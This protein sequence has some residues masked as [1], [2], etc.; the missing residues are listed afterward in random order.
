MPLRP[1]NWLGMLLALSLL[2]ARVFP[3]VLTATLQPGAVDAWSRYTQEAERSLTRPRPLLDV[4]GERP[5]FRDLNPDGDNAGAEVPN[6]YIHHWIG[7]VRIPNT[8]VAAVR[9]VLEDYSHYLRTYAPD[10]KLAA[11]I[12]V[13]SADGPN[14]GR[15]YDLHMISDQPGA[16]GLHFAFD[17]R[18]RVHFHDNQGD[19]LIDS[20]SYSIRESNSSKAP[21]TDLLPEGRDHGIL[22]RLNS[23]WRLRQTGTSVYAECQVI[24]LSRKPLFGLREVIKNRARASLESTLRR[25]LNRTLGRPP[26]ATIPDADNASL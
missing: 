20:R 15:T 9:A 13:P 8:T 23:Y 4:A 1:R 7:A 12:M 2:P 21:Y 10:L 11:A 22:W 16:V 18:S 24:S 26:G 19:V 6:A 3:A 25:T 5:V 14:S 17:L